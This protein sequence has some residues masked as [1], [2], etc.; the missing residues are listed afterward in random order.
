[1]VSLLVQYTTGDGYAMID[2]AMDGVPWGWESAGTGAVGLVWAA[3][4]GFL[5]VVYTL[6][7]QVG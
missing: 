3:E 1:M 6:I 4:S 7:R 2:F 5:A